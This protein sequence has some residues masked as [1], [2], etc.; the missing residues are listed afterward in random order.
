MLE[1]PK[2]GIKCQLIPVTTELTF[3]NGETAQVT[4]ACRVTFPTQPPSQ[5]DFDIV[6][7]GMF[8]CWMPLGQMKNKRFTL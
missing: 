1:A 4:Q 7:Q 5:T 2:Y 6:E 8:Q 3:A